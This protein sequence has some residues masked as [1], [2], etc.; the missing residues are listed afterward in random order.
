MILK[1]WE[2]GPELGDLFNDVAIA[3]MG[4]H[5][6]I[7]V[8]QWYPP[9][10]PT[11]VVDKYIIISSEKKKKIE[12]SK[13]I[14]AKMHTITRL[15]EITFWL[16]HLCFHTTKAIVSM[17]RLWAGLPKF[18]SRRLSFKVYPG[19]QYIVAIYL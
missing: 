9:Y 2:V 19:I 16:G 5:A 10:P 14:Q 11:L 4:C 12:T 3:R 8:Q 18:Q 1:M 7:S 13:N 6:P 15:S 17:K